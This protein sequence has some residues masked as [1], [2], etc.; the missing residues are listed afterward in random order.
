MESNNVFDVFDTIPL[1]L[2]QPL[3][4]ACPP[5]LRC[6]QPPVVCLQGIQGS[7]YVSFL[8][9]YSPFRYWLRF[10]HVRAAGQPSGQSVAL[11]TGR[12]Q[13]Q[14]PEL[15]R[16]KS[17]VLPLNRQL[18]HCS[19]A[20]IENKNLFLTDLPGKINVSELVS[21][22][23]CLYCIS[24]LHNDQIICMIIFSTPT[25]CDHDTQVK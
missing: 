18:T 13:V 21:A 22:C 9:M 15:I 12:L 17:V 20:V 2:L 23:V 14:T 16:Y 3:P 19:Q 4:G 5:K 25:R 8:F 10:G 1:I 24:G 11:V 6:H 7:G